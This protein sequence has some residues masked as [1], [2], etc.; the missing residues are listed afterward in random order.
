MLKARK[1]AVAAVAAIFL[2]G[3]SSTPQEDL[4]VPRC[5]STFDLHD[6]AEPLGSGERLVSIIQFGDH[7]VLTKESVLT[8]DAEGWI[9]PQQ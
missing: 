4:A 3:C 7:D 8:V 9:V 6:K 2:G 5:E 1:I